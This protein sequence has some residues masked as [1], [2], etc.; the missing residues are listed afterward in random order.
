MLGTV[1]SLQICE[2]HR[3]PMKKVEQAVLITDVGI[4]GDIHASNQIRP[5]PVPDDPVSLYR[6]KERQILLMDL[7]TLQ[8]FNLEVG[9]IKE[10]ITTVGIDINQLKPG[11]KIIV[12]EAAILTVTGPCTPCDR[13][14]EIRSG[15]MDDIKGERGTLTFVEIGGTIRVGDDI[16]VVDI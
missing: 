3:S 11:Q 10:N 12:G 13:M 4:E 6:R 5:S 16:L 2:S 14:D 7:E 8:K 15:L 9:V 1:H